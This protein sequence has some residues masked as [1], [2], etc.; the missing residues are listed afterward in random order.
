MLLRA[1]LLMESVSIT[2]G[3]VGVETVGEAAR[4]LLEKLDA[5]VARERTG[6]VVTQYFAEERPPA[7]Q[8]RFDPQMFTG[9]EGMTVRW[10]FRIQMRQ[11]AAGAIAG[12]A[13]CAPSVA[14]PALLIAVNDNRQGHDAL[15][16]ETAS[17]PFSLDR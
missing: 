10:F 11:A 17:T 12:G 4:R 15:R 3:G 8:R 16:S 2:E 14:S 9:I 13:S 7:N 6:G 1:L 5:R